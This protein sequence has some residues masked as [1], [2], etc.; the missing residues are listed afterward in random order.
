MSIFSRI[1]EYV[2]YYFDSI[3]AT[4]LKIKVENFIFNSAHEDITVVY[5]LGRQK[6]LNKMNLLQFER[7]YFENVSNY[8]QHR[9]TKF[10]ILQNTLRSLFSKNS[11]D[12]EQFTRFI[13]E[14]IKNEQ[15]F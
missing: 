7:E 3:K 12:R 2:H 8:D 5:R 9:L 10:S 13:E 15:L 6:L 1:S 4:G 14:E 11:C